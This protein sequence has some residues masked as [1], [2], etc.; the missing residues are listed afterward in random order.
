M[1]MSRQRIIINNKSR[2]SSR[3]TLGKIT[4]TTGTKNT[5]SMKTEREDNRTKTN[6]IDKTKGIIV[7]T[8]ITKSIQTIK[9]MKT[10]PRRILPSS[11]RCPKVVP[12]SSS[13]PRKRV[14]VQRDPILKMPRSMIKTTH[15]VK[16]LLK[17]A[18]KIRSKLVT[19][20]VKSHW[21][22]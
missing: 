11:K 18:T 8:T 10:L 1:A 14:M 9:A 19:K 6:N 3:I 13:T 7:I 4:E 22:W 15:I 20:V 2:V 16:W 12:K 21:K 5:I 17:K